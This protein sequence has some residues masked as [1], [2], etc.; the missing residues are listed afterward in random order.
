MSRHVVD[1]G[2][3]RQ[4]NRS[5]GAVVCAE[6]DKTDRILPLSSASTHYS[7]TH[8]SAI[9]NH[10]MNSSPSRILAR[11][12]T[13]VSSPSVY[14]VLSCP[15]GH[16]GLFGFSGL[17]IGY[18]VIERSNLKAQMDYLCCPSS[19]ISCPLH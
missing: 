11:Q 19:A 3:R 10:A 7:T 9:A 6:G 15:H 17:R 4:Q 2:T 12:H 1:E 14:F 16:S 8:R 13:S 18:S 5:P